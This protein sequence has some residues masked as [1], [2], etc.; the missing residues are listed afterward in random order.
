[1]YHQISTSFWGTL[2][3]LQESEKETKRVQKQ[4]ESYVLSKTNISKKQLKR[5]FN[6]KEDLYLTA[7]EA[8][9]LGVIDEIIKSA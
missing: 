8:Q 9:E 5:V 2:K 7:L 6:K 3:D 4:W 1:M